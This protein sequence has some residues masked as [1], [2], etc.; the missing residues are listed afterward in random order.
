MTNY[1]LVFIPATS[2]GAA[3]VPPVR[4]DERAV[5]LQLVQTA[6][7][8]RKQ[9]VEIT[10]GDWRVLRIVLEKD[11]DTTSDSGLVV[12]LRRFAFTSNLSRLF[13]FDFK[14][15]PMSSSSSSLYPL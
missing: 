9:T 5:P 14:P 15:P 4:F 13:A 7:V 6:A 1:R 2:V 12:S 10:T 11:V 8:T 3:A